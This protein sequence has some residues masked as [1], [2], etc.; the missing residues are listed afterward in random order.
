MSSIQYGSYCDGTVYKENSFY[1]EEL[2]IALVLYVDDFV[3]KLKF[4]TLWAHREKSIKSQLYTG[5][6]A[7]SLIHLYPL[8]T[9]YTW[10]FYAKQLISKDL[11]MLKC[12][13]HC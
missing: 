12:L 8:L 11:A 3:M 2:R 10:P 5:S 13:L 7:T 9:H 1:S 6:L 4:V